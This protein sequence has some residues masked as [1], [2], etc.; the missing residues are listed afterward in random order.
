VSGFSIFTTETAEGST[1]EGKI[2]N[3]FKLDSMIFTKDLAPKL[4][5]SGSVSLF[6]SDGLTSIK[7][8]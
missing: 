3:I 2:D 8:A 4:L 6:N 5:N 7:V 1:L